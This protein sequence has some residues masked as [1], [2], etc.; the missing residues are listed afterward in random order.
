[1]LGDARWLCVVL[2]RAQ[3][4]MLIHASVKSL[5]AQPLTAQL[6]DFCAQRSLLPAPVVHLPS[7]ALQ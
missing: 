5:R 3:R 1:L 4:T 6:V 7:D 2:T